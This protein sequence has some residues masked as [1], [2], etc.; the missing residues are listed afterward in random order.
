MTSAVWRLGNKTTVSVAIGRKRKVK[1]MGIIRKFPKSDNWFIQLVRADGSRGSASTRFVDRKLAQ[2]VLDAADDMVKQDQLITRT[3]L[4]ELADR[5][6]WCALKKHFPREKVVAYFVGLLDEC[7]GSDRA[8]KEQAF[9]SFAASLTTHKRDQVDMLELVASDI[10]QWKKEMIKANLANRT[11]RGYLG[12]VRWGLNVAVKRGVAF[13]NVALLVD[14]PK[15]EKHS[16]RRPFTRDELVRV[17]NGADPEWFDMILFGAATGLRLCDIAL[18]VYRDLDLKTGFIRPAVRKSRMFEPKPIPPFLLEYLRKK[19]SPQDLDLPLHPRA[20][21]AVLDYAGNP[22]KLCG[23]FK[24][25]LIDV[26][27]RDPKVKVRVG[28]K[29][30][31]GAEKYV[32]L[33]FHCLKHSYVTLLKA[34]AVTEALARQLAGHRS[35]VISDIYTHLGE[36]IMSLAVEEFPDLLEGVKPPNESNFAHPQLVLFGHQPKAQPSRLA[37]AALVAQQFGK[38]EKLAA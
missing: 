35:Q 9:A 3:G 26:G 11:I 6:C 17:L 12:L 22:T 34:L 10:S 15:R 13:N 14:M 18:L 27:V 28:Q 7:T 5:L 30:R 24:K 16:N 31:L 29:E 2:I 8:V 25:L 36:E 1:G 4:L 20:Y 32:P 33:T 21:Q 23:E 37:Q 19:T 38:P